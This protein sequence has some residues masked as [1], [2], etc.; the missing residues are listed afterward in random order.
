[1]RPLVLDGVVAR[2]AT[3]DAESPPAEGSTPLFEVVEQLLA[4][5]LVLSGAADDRERHRVALLVH[6]ERP[7]EGVS[8]RLRPI[9]M[10]R[11][12]HVPAG[13]LV[14]DDAE[15]GSWAAFPK[16]LRTSSAMA[17]RQRRSRVSGARGGKRPA[18]RWTYPRS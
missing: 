6:A 11:A 9:T 18:G 2:L 16:S 7:D 1:V 10:E 8:A 4:G 14:F 13:V 17:C 5:R 12:F 3:I 15:I